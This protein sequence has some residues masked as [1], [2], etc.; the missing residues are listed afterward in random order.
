MF[1]ETSWYNLPS[2]SY[3]GWENAIFTLGED[4]LTCHV[5]VRWCVGNKFSLMCLVWTEI[6]H[7]LWCVLCG[8]REYIHSSVSYVDWVMYTPTCPRWNGCVALVDACMISYGS[9]KKTSP[10]CGHALVIE[11]ATH[12][13]GLDI[14]LPFPFHLLEMT[15]P[16]HPQ[17]IGHPL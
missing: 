16:D 5:L 3:V 8:P 11:S 10:D 4:T 7:T 2:V 14:C 13:G 15:C 9:I 17:G 12:L 1:E 6:I